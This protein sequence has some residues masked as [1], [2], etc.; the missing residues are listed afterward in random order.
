MVDC[1]D[2][3][4]SPAIPERLGKDQVLI[5]FLI[6]VPWN[7]QCSRYHFVGDKPSKE[8][9]QRKRERREF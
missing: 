5:T 8:K 9:K 6:K 4:T 2:Q 7:E 1:S 3:P